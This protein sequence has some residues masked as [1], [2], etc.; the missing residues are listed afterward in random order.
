MARTQ[1]FPKAPNCPTQTATRSKVTL[2]LKLNT[3]P[4]ECC[5]TDCDAESVQIVSS[6]STLKTC[7]KRKS[8]RHK[9]SAWTATR[10]AGNK[11]LAIKLS[12]S[13]LTKLSY[14]AEDGVMEFAEEDND[15]EEEE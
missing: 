13:L 9:P 5:D 3:K 10:A 14:C 1:L 7:S 6:A 12:K 2:K 11:S 15:Q 8:P 4:T